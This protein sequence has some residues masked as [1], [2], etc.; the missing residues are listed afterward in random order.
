MRIVI[1]KIP[2]GLVHYR[3]HG[4]ID[5]LCGTKGDSYDSSKIYNSRV[6][7]KCHKI[8]FIKERL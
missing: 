8:Y 6:C 4:K 3:K 7:N 5:Y 2:K 1:R